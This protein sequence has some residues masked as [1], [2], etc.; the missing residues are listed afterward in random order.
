MAPHV[1]R[2]ALLVASVL[3]AA[4]AG[5]APAP[6]DQRYNNLDTP[7]VGIEPRSP[8]LYRYENDWQRNKAW[9]ERNN[10]ERYLP[11]PPPKQTAPDQDAPR[12]DP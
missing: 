9:S 11:L 6:I 2:R 10:P 12:N 3:L 5:C 8:Y 4:E 7:A 1:Y